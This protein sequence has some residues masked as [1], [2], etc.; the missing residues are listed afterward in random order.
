MAP[1]THHDLNVARGDLK[2]GD[3][4]RIKAQRAAFSF[5]SLFIFAI[6]LRAAVAGRISQARPQLVVPDGAFLSV[7]RDPFKWFVRKAL[8]IQ[9]SK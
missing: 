2:P 6:D 4:K 5:N 9:K 8:A 1:G 7:M 3:I